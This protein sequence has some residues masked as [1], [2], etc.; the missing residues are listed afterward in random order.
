M[1]RNTV[2]VGALQGWA[3]AAPCC[4]TEGNREQLWLS[5]HDGSD[6][7]Y[8][9]D[10]TCKPVHPLRST[11]G[12]PSH[13][14][15]QPHT[16]SVILLPVFIVVEH[17]GQN[18]QI[19][20]G[21]YFLGI[22]QHQIPLIVT[23][24]DVLFSDFSQYLYLTQINTFVLETCQRLTGVHI[25]CGGCT[26]E[27]SACPAKCMRWSAQSFRQWNVSRS[28]LWLNL[29]NNQTQISTNRGESCPPLH[30]ALKYCWLTCIVY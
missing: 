29:E 6:W 17:K 10:L 22:R 16:V 28:D 9:A 20:F 7:R 19:K 11:R 5:D 23:K 1:L 3:R 13:S 14:Y 24:Y 4:C 21:M 15:T 8:S 18:Y 25:P 26:R 30:P 12:W 2:P 27:L